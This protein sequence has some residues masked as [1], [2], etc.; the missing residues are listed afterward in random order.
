[1]SKC[2]EC[3]KETPEK[4]CRDCFEIIASGTL[5]K[6]LERPVAVT[7]RDR[8]GNQYAGEVLVVNPV[9]LGIK[10][11]APMGERYELVLMGHL[12][13]KVA[14]VRGKGKG[15]VKVFDI[16]QVVREQAISSRLNNDEY[17]LLTGSAGQLVDDITE[18]LPE[19]VREIARQRLREEL[20]KS[21]LLDSLRVGQVLKYERGKFKYLSGQKDM[22][23]PINELN[24]LMQ[25]ATR[26]NSHQREIYINA[27]GNRMFDLHGIPFD[28]NRGGVLAFDIT[29]VIERERE[30][31]KREMKIYQEVIA[32]VTGG[33]F[34]IIHRD[35]S[36]H[37]QAEGEILH[38][39][40]VSKPKD[41][42]QA[43][44]QLRELITFLPVKKSQE[45][46][47]CLSEALTNTLKHAQGSYWQLSR[48]GDILRLSV[49]DQGPGISLADLPKATLMKHYSSKNSMGC[50]FTIMLYF[51]DRLFLYT[52]RKGTIVTMDFSNLQFEVNVPVDDKV[53]G[54]S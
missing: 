53:T 24:A 42:A 23:L 46:I 13:L 5:R 10:T 54:C 12:V 39:G 44:A 20:Q 30:A 2:V 37:L 47:L 4:P 3:A 16:I 27:D 35:H 38:R 7:L 31:Y 21:E 25:E 48:I 11:N 17:K 29:E 33:R 28:Y 1:M 43:R 49:S 36:E 19:N 8:Q 40:S 45:I 15:E 34:N 9:E 51:S 52:G 6:V 18:N 50:G 32:A 22:D 14:P 41:L 26:K